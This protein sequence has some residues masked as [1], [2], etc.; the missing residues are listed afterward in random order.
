MASDVTVESINRAKDS[1]SKGEDIREEME[2][3]V[4]PHA[5]W[6]NF[7]SPAP[8]CICL[9][10]E[11]MVISTTADFTLENTPPR[12]GFKLMRWPSSFRASLMQ[13]ANWGYEAFSEA[14]TSMDQIR[15]LSLNVPVHMREAVKILIKGTNKE[16]ESLLP[17]KLKAIEKVADEG[18]R[19]AT[20]V[21]AKFKDVMSLTAELLEACVGARGKYE[22]D[23]QETEIALEIAKRNKNIAEERKRMTTKVYKELEKSVE[24]AEKSYY[25]SLDSM[26]SGWQIIAMNV[27]EGIGHAFVN[28][29]S[30][31]SRV[32]TSQTEDSR[33]PKHSRSPKSAEPVS[34]RM[35]LDDGTIKSYQKAILLKTYTDLLIEATINDGKLKTNIEPND[36]RITYAEQQFSNLLKDVHSLDKD[37]VTA[38]IINLLKEGLDVV[39]HIKKIQRNFQVH[40]N[41]DTKSSLAE[42][43][44]SFYQSVFALESEGK[45]LLWSSPTDMRAPNQRAMPTVP[46][47]DGSAA[48]LHIQNT[49]FKTQQTAA[50][51]EFVRDKFDKVFDNLQESNQKLGDTI[52]E[53]AK[54]DIRKIDFE[55][56]R[57]TLIKG[58]K[59]LGELRGQWGKLVMF[60]Q[61][62]SNLIRCS[63][64]TSLEDFTGQAHALKGYPVTALRK[65]L[66][67]QQAFQASKLAHLVNMISEC[68]VKISS[69]HLVEQVAG[70]GKLLG[71]DPATEE[72]E[73]L[74]EREALHQSCAKA[75]NEIQV[76][77][78][79]HKREFDEKVESRIRRIKEELENALPQQILEP[80]I[81]DTVHQA[82]GLGIKHAKEIEETMKTS[83][84]DPDDFV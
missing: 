9:L 26:P 43:I 28:R 83:S 6:E 36:A 40:A 75:Q 17:I 24:D 68:Y 84:L 12:D 53:L 55:N 80:R 1:L 16:V 14:H 60:F 44:L 79:K 74:R 77:V 33:K 8:M 21:E 62:I 48:K 30:G 3:V 41:E 49:R 69:D 82:I 78:L 72:K 63:L 51:L 31:I 10:G 52:A 65:D 76:L 54:L 73:I 59:A 45:A 13:V 35:S 81:G 7:L 58:I 56:I 42:R 20:S 64:N 18:L 22:A 61:M 4:S 19:L 38:Q 66:I 32:F 15:L 70:L 27:V 50:Q 57:K 37:T 46:D 71:F 23:L 67:Y 11:L 34:T 39:G 29:L 2:L 47:T 25:S 5:N